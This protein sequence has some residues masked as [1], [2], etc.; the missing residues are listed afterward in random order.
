VKKK[1]KRKKHSRTSWHLLHSVLRE[2]ERVWPLKVKSF[3]VESWGTVRVCLVYVYLVFFLPFFGSLF[4][5]ILLAYR[6]VC[7]VLNSD[8]FLC[9]E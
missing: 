5:L 2:K 1:N 8:S 3:S 7:V 4:V 6:W 9:L